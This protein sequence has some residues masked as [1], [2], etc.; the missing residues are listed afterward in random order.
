MRWA[1]PLA[2]RAAFELDDTAA[3]RDL[4]ALLDYYQPGYLAPALRAE[5]ALARARLDGHHGD[6]DAAAAFA[7]AVTGLR[8]LSIPYH[9]A[10]GLLDHAEY[11]TALGDTTA[12]A[13]AIGEARDIAH[14]LRCQPLLHRAADMTPAEPPTR[15]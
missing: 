6:P 14:H 7:S 12:A 8:E 2:A 11:L 1:W 4:L 5:R 15:A 13:M 9:L 3:T 10:G